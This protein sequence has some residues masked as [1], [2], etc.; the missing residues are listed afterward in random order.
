MLVRNTTL[1][2]STYGKLNLPLTSSIYFVFLPLEM[3]KRLKHTKVYHALCYF[4]WKETIHKPLK[5]APA[6]I[7][8]SSVCLIG[9]TCF[10]ECFLFYVTTGS[11]Y[12][13]WK[14]IAPYCC[15]L[16]SQCFERSPYFMCYLQ[17][18]NMYDA[19]TKVQK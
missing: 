8:F 16:S 19:N 4:A 7:L 3:Q 13:S 17:T 18:N 10:D 14:F 11:H 12:F 15:F 1:T 6:K 2:I 5:V 9:T